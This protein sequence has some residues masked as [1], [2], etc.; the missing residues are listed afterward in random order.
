MSSI[1]STNV[2]TIGRK[3]RINRR[4]S[5]NERCDD[6][7]QRAMPNGCLPRRGLVASTFV[8]AA[9]ASRHN[10]SVT[11]CRNGLWFGTR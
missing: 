11:P 8:R 7:N 6:S 9:I 4:A 10:T 1:V 5:G 2:S 3:T